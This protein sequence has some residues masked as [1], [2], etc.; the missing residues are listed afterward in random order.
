MSLVNRSR[1]ASLLAAVAL[2]ACADD[3]IPPTGPSAAGPA[4]AKQ[5]ALRGVIP[6]R[7][8]ERPGTF[9]DMPDEALWQHVAFSGG[10]AVVGLKAPGAARGVYRGEVLVTMAEASQ[11]RQAVGRH[12]GVTVIA[13]DDRL[14]LLDV[15]IA[16]LDALR[17]LRGLPIVDY[18]EPVRARGDI[19]QW[20][21]VGGCGWPGAWEGEP[22]ATTATGDRYSPRFDAMGIPAAWDV[23]SGGRRTSGAG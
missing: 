20:G 17:K 19:A 3:A 10:R 23:S 11:A 7:A 2:A 22:L 1:S 13:T 8:Q 15:E 4:A 12:P 5:P 16:T 9:A 21:S 6:T 18:V 14:P